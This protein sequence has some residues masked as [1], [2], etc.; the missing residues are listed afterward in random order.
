MMYFS[1]SVAKKKKEGKKFNY[2]LLHLRQFFPMG[3]AEMPTLTFLEI[4]KAIF[5]PHPRQTYMAFSSSWEWWQDFKKTS[6]PRPAFRRSPASPG[7]CWLVSN[8]QLEILLVPRLNLS[9]LVI[10]QHES[11][12]Y[13]TPACIPPNASWARRALTANLKFFI[14]TADNFSPLAAARQA[15]H[16][17]PGGFQ[18]S[19]MPLL[20]TA[21][22]KAGRKPS[23]AR[24]WAFCNRN[25]HCHFCSAGFIFFFLSISF[26]RSPIRKKHFSYKSGRKG[27]H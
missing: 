17:A 9:K 5:P 3:E 25:A 11:V 24:Y 27:G 7:S 1:V 18:G 12:F 2:F 10:S 26:I 8:M 20:G 22:T 23:W 16:A 14:L 15:P 21:G 13:V 4:T 6:T 19:S